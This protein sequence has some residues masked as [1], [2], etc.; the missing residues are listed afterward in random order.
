MARV[1]E[2]VQQ[3]KGQTLHTLT[4][5]K[6]FDVVEV[7]QDR[8]LIVPHDGIGMQRSIGREQIEHM[9]NLHQMGRITSR[10]LVQEEYPDNQNTSY[11]AT[12]VA[13]ITST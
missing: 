5:N 3:L 4:R 12:I 2:R 7:H 13:A 9:F 10:K 8:V 6:A 11:I 1:W